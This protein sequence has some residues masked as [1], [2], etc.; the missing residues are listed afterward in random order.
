[1]TDRARKPFAWLGEAGWVLLPVFLLANAAVTGWLMPVLQVKDPTYRLFPWIFAGAGLAAAVP[2][3]GR[4]LVGGAWYLRLLPLAVYATVIT[5]ASSVSG[6]S[7]A[8]VSGNV[9]HPVEYA[10]LG[11]LA[12]LLAHRGLT[13]R[14]AAPRVGLVVLAC[15]AFG[16]LDELHQRFVPTRAMTLED[17]GLDALGALVGTAIYLLLAAITTSSRPSAS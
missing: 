14:P 12:Q 6:V 4:A 11:F 10:G 7:P 17:V 1:L 8:G 3:V 15:V 5:L 16:G 9:F 2:A 13:L